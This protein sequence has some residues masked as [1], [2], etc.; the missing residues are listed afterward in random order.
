MTINVSNVNEAPTSLMMGNATSISISNP[1]FEAQ[2]LP[3]FPTAGW[4]VN[5]ITGWTTTGSNT[6]IFNP[7][8]NSYVSDGS[9]VA[10]IDN[11][12]TISQTLSTN[13]AAKTEITY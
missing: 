7:N 5:T 11:G 1:G 9:N 10:Y 3:D 2:S 8:Q 6:G 4:A 12:G 13:F